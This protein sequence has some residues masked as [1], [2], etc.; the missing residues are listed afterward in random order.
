V[1]NR[2]DKETKCVLLSIGMNFSLLIWIISAEMHG[3]PTLYGVFHTSLTLMLMY[4]RQKGNPTR[5]SECLVHLCWGLPSLLPV[6]P[7]TVRFLPC[8]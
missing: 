6:P 8:L 1:E 2:R 4:W 7:S 3:E 5:I